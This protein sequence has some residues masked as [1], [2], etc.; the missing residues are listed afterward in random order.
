MHE[1]PSITPRPK[2]Q[3]ISLLNTGDIALAFNNEELIGWLVALPYSKRVQELGMAYILPE[4][5]NSGLLVRLIS[6]LIDKR[7]VS[8]AVTYEERL[9]GLLVERWSFAPTSLSKLTSISRGKFIS[10]RL[11]SART[12][13][14]V[15][16]HVSKTKPIYL[17]REMAQ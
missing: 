7:P 14:A 2:Q 4:Y 1:V 15:V 5:R 12:A 13:R 17:M 10:S 3:L 6:K 16:S 9:A 11:R 8:L